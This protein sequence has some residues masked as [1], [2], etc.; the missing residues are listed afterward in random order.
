M[1]SCGPCLRRISSKPEADFKH[2]KQTQMSRTQTSRVP[3]RGAQAEPGLPVYRE[4]TGGA[5][6]ACLPG[7][8]RDKRY[9]A[10]EARVASLESQGSAGPAFLPCLAH[11]RTRTHACLEAHRRR[12]P[13]LL[14]TAAQAAPG[15]VGWEA[16]TSPGATPP[17]HDA[18]S[19][20]P[21]P[22][23]AVTAGTLAAFMAKRRRRTRRHTALVAPQRGRRGSHSEA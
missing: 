19:V 1:R 11:R 4:V 5:G 12:Q 22:A 9:G 21:G 15:Q 18:R 7:L 8:V 2:T 3:G 13:C 20:Y 16:H 10:R 23:R 6:P 17:R 14:A